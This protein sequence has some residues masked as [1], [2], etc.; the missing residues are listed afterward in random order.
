MPMC[1]P[2]FQYLQ[3]DLHN[4]LINIG[5][6]ICSTLCHITRQ[7]K[8]SYNVASDAARL[9]AAASGA[10]GAEIKIGKLSSLQTLLLSASQQSFG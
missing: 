5:L 2:E 3:N 6:F 4:T 1:C 7:A 9:K 10:V 8:L